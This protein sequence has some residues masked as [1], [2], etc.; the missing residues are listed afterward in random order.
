MPILVFKGTFF[1]D[2]NI[3]HIKHYRMP[4]RVKVSTTGFNSSALRPA[5]HQDNMSV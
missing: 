3:C 4:K 1:Q 5:I 2:Q